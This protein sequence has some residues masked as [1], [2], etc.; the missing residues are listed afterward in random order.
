MNFSIERQKRR[1]NVNVF[2]HNA[3]LAAYSVII[4]EADSHV[5]DQTHKSISTSFHFLHAIQ[6]NAP[7]RQILKRR[8]FLA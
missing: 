2:T 6:P 4:S 3:T 8:V 7:F 5:A 1:F